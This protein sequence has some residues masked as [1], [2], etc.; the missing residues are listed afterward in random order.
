MEEYLGLLRAKKAVID[1]RVGEANEQIGVIREAL[2]EHGIS[3]ASPPS[4]DNSPS[5]DRY[6]LPNSTPN[7]IR[8]PSQY[9]DITSEDPTAVTAESVTSKRQ[10]IMEELMGDLSKPDS[11]VLD[12][13]GCP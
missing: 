9:S 11:H 2:D 10:Q 13:S 12:D 8:S 5:S 7:V 3:E 4:T 6:P 1:L